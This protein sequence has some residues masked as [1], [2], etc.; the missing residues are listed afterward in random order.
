MGIWVVFKELRNEDLKYR[1]VLM[2]RV[3]YESGYFLFGRFDLKIC[4]LLY[5]NY[6]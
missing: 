3:Y 4:Y 5:I 2:C 1:N 6:V